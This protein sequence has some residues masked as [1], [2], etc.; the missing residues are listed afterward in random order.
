MRIGRRTDQFA[1]NGKTPKSFMIVYASIAVS[2]SRHTGG[3]FDTY[4]LH[5]LSPWRP[6]AHTALGSITTNNQRHRLLKLLG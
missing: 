2:D 6:S 5:P 1:R 4:R 3:V